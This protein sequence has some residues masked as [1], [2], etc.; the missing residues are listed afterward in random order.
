MRPS[1]PVN[2]AKGCSCAGDGCGCWDECNGLEGE[3]PRDF[4]LLGFAGS[5]S[6]ARLVMDDGVSSFL[7][8]CFRQTSFDLICR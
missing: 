5:V 2:R 1:R 6:L 8:V 3:A 4:V 7:S